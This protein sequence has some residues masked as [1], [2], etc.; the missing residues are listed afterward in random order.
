MEKNNK[1][2]SKQVLP[3]ISLL[4]RVVVIQDP[5]SHPCVLQ[6]QDRV[7]SNN[8]NN[9]WANPSKVRTAALTWEIAPTQTLIINTR[10]DPHK[11]WGVLQC[12]R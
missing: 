8:P 6:Q 12:S 5:I 4:L 2:Y 3:G 9:V 11:G 10:I 7:T 1:R